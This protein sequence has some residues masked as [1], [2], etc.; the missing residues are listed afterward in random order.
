MHLVADAHHLNRALVSTDRPVSVAKPESFK[1]AS[2]NTEPEAT[3]LFSKEPGDH[4]R[5]YRILPQGFPS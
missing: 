5:L 3:F 1:V 4:G 2:T